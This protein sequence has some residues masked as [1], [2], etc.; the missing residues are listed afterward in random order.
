MRL[1][2][3]RRTAVPQV[4]LE[5]RVLNFVQAKVMDGGS[6]INAQKYTRSKP[7]AVVNPTLRF[8][9]I[10]KL[11]VCVASVM[12]SLISSNTSAA[13]IMIAERCTDHKNRAQPNKQD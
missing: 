1:V 11:R 6:T 7:D 10:A 5:N 9:G 13:T 4:H 8:I 12:P 3:W 2:N